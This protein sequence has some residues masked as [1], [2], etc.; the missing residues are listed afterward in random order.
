MAE[1]VSALFRKDFTHL[2]KADIYV[3]DF[4]AGWRVSLSCHSLK[5]A[6]HQSGFLAVHR[7]IYDAQ[8]GTRKSGKGRVAGEGRGGERRGQ[9][10]FFTLKE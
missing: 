3:L 6:L 4:G 5:D 8:Q 7:R 9:W 2:C 10:D 1:R